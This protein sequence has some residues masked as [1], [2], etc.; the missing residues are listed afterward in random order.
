MA[1]F[2]VRLTAQPLGNLTVSVSRVSGD[3]DI[4]VAWGD[5]LAFTLDNWNTNQQVILTA[6]QDDDVASRTAIIRCSCPGLDSQDIVAIEGDDDTMEILP[7]TNRVMVPEG[8]SASFQVQLSAQPLF[9]VNVTARRFGFIDP[10][11]DVVGGTNQFT[12]TSANWNDP[13]TV[14]VRARQDD[15]D[16]NGTAIIRITGRYVIGPLL[17][18][19]EVTAVEADDDFVLLL[20]ATHEQDDVMLRW[21]GLPDTAYEVQWSTN[22]LDWS[23]IP[24]GAVTQWVDS[25]WIAF[26]QKFYRL[27][28]D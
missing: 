7:S 10:D 9:D 1:T 19:V 11:L 23:T 3:P 24:V 26:P 8:G 22:L 16:F 5:S 6:A 4:S 28:S 25:T 27:R 20:Q 21:N 12:F 17:P 14:T 13:R 15:D 2:D 18:T